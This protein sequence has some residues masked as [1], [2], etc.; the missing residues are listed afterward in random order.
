[1]SKLRGLAYLSRSDEGR[2]LLFANPV[3]QF[4]KLLLCQGTDHE[5]ADP[6]ESTI[7]L[8]RATGGIIA[9]ATASSITTP[10]DTIKTR[11]QLDVHPLA[12]IKK[13]GSNS[14]SGTVHALAIIKKNGSN[15]TSGTDNE[16]TNLRIL[17]LL[18]SDLGAS[19][20]NVYLKDQIEM[21]VGMNSS[22][23]GILMNH[24][25]PYHPDSSYFREQ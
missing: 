6:S 13:N 17:T 9:G 23:A 22:C 21:C 8:V 7:M 12:I 3:D 25:N 19:N 15:S 18:L 20:S 2:I 11:L 16:M 5:G 24:G 1:M 4:A 10:L 14:T